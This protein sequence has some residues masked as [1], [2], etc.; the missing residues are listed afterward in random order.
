MLTYTPCVHQLL[1]KPKDKLKLFL[2]I[3]KFTSLNL[4]S[5]LTYIYRRI[6]QIFSEYN[7]PD[8]S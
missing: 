8:Y 1:Q 5:I 6:G 3:Y 4:D 2:S 7:T